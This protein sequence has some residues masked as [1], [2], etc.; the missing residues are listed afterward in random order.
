MGI[1]QRS[2]ATNFMYYLLPS[3][4]RMHEHQ[5]QKKDVTWNV[6]W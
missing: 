6:G 3:G 1:K 2:R 5:H 4:T